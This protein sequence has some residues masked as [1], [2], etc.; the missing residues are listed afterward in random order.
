MRCPWAEGDDLMGAY[1]DTEWGKPVRTEDGMFERLC[2]EAFQSGLSWSTILRK[3]PAFRTAFKEFSPAEVAGFTEKDFDRLMADVGIV[4]NRLKI[5]AAIT[6]AQATLALEGGLA[7]LIWSFA[8]KKHKVPTTLADVPAVTDESVALAK[9]LKAAG[10]VFVGPTTAYA[11]MQAAGLVN[12]HLA[13][14]PAR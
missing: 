12:D 10:F 2:L 3:R 6:N 1:H 14:C 11:T 5:R 8:P 9:G 13:S 7:D 4:R